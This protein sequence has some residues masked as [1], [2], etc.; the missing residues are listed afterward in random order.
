MAA[1]LAWEAI[2]DLRPWEWEWRLRDVEPLWIAGIEQNPK[3]QFPAGH[4]ERLSAIRR[5]AE[6]LLPDRLAGVHNLPAAKLR[7]RGDAS[8]LAAV[9][10]YLVADREGP[11]L[12][13]SVAARMLGYYH[14]VDGRVKNGWR[15]LYSEVRDFRN[16][17]PEADSPPK[18]RRIES[19]RIVPGQL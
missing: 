10:H 7:D 13:W 18:G 6:W 5:R 19:Y 8:V 11:Q 9:S 1:R 4:R 14:I 3:A 12:P 17:H 2:T 15:T 16:A